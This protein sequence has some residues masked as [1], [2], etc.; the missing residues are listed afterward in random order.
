MAEVTEK[1]YAAAI[2]ACCFYQR[3]QEHIDGLGLCWGLTLAI[4]E[5]RTMDCSRCD[6]AVRPA[7]HPGSA[8]LPAADPNPPRF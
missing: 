4:E 5:G 6:L 8:T 3:L 2:P 1:T 7:I